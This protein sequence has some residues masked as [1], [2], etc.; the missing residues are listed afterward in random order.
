[1][2]NGLE[3]QPT[4]VP[5]Y[6]STNLSGGLSALRE[7][8]ALYRGDF[9]AG[10]Y[11]DWMVV[12]RERLRE[13]FLAALERLLALCKAG[14]AYEEALGYAQRLV[15]EDPLREAGHR[16]VMRLCHLLGRSNKALQQYELCRAVLAEELGAEPTAATT[17][18]YREI[19]ARAGEAEGLYLPQAATPRPALL[20]EGT[21]QV[22]LVGRAQERSVLL[23]HLERAIG[24]RGGL[25]LLEGEAGVGKTRLLQEVARD[26]GWR[27]MEVSW[28]HGRELADAPPYTPLVEALRGALSPL[29]AGQLAH[30]VEAEWRREAGQLLPELGAAALPDGRAEAHGPGTILPADQGRARLLEALARVTLALGRITPHLLILEDLHWADEATLEAL[31][32]LAP[33][34]A[35]GRIAVI[36]S[37]RSGEARARPAVWQALQALDR[38]G[39]QRI[40]LAPLSAGETGELV[41]R[42]LGL[43]QEAPRFAARLYRETEG[44]PLFVLETLRAL[45]DEGLLY[46][47]QAGEWST[48]WDETTADYAEL[49]LPA[50][51]RQV[52]ARRLA[53]L[54]PDERAALNAAAVLGAEFDLPLFL[55]MSGPDHP[56]WLAAAGGLVRRRLLEE[57]PAAYR[58]SHDQVRRV[59]Y[60][61][62][63]EGE[64]RRLHRQAGEALE[65]LQPQAV[66]AL[67][68][69]FTQG[70]VRDKAVAYGLQ[71]G[72]QAQALYAYTEAL[73]RYDQALALADE[74]DGATRWELHRR[75]EATLD[76]LGRR[77]EQTAGL[78]EMLRLAVAL[79]DARRRA[80]T[81]YR[82]GRLA[83][84]TGAPRQGLALLQEAND[85]AR[86][87][88]D[89]R[90]AGECQVAIGRAHW[91]L[92]EIPPCLAAA[93]AAQALFQAANDRRGEAGALNLMGN[94]YLGLLGNHEQALRCFEQVAA[95]GREMGD[96]LLEHS[97]HCNAGIALMA[98]GCYRE[99]QER[100][101]RARAFFTQIDYPLY[102]AI[103]AFAQANNHL[104]LGE[105]A[106]A[107]AVAMERAHAIESPELQSSFLENVPE[108]REIVAAY[109]A[110]QTGEQSV[111]VRLPRSGVPTG[112]PL[113][114]DERVEVTWTV[115]AAEDGEVA[116]KTAHRRRR[117]LRLLAEAAEQ[118][119]APT[120]DDLAAALHVSRATIKRDLAGLRAGGQEARTRGSR[121]G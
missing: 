1:M 40:E 31:I 23:G 58:F 116:G 49:P 92:G 2:G 14:G 50:G 55:H 3:G 85:L 25:I 113:R 82:Q 12:E 4:N 87:C 97:A 27:G 51:V 48:P 35:A 57:G 28:G 65:A 56:A 75:K 90:L 53:R 83:T 42:A 78:A 73:A 118:G 94:L 102:L 5:I 37:Y 70:Q 74:R 7:A 24:D 15:A 43:A 95:L 18:L 77:E 66:A 33:Q 107:A 11:D 41:R 6:R 110:W 106:A 64:R 38:A 9:L 108:N 88:G 79:D 16:E 68:Y 117:L 120:V 22:P 44:N 91:H 99:S 105:N 8:V 19:A 67:A 32:R 111:R 61:E 104:G 60:A 72:E 21:G 17:V 93:E 100:L 39:C 80:V 45:H 101:S 121:S 34:L 62:L 36:G 119:A 20:L 29:R 76:V 112:R 84:G 71:A 81:L 26:A 30:L 109:R 115:S 86:E 54:G 13:L 63:P 46:R 10:F 52:I 47:D 114:E 89:L 98:L 59:A 69:H 96:G 103:I